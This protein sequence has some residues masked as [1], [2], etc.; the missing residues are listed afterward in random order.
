[1]WGGVTENVA[2]EDHQEQ[3]PVGTTV[4]GT[5]LS[6][7]K[8]LLS[9]M[10]GDRVAH[11]LL[12]T[13]ANID[14]DVRMKASYNSLLLLALLPV[15]KFTGVPK[16]LHGILENRVIHAC[17]DLICEPLKVVARH[18]DW[19]SDHAGN[20]RYCYT[21]IV[22]YIADTP[23]A[24][25]LV[26]VS[27]KT[28]HL[29][30]A[31]GP[32]FGD[33]FQ[34]PPRT[35]S[36]ILSPLSSLSSSMDPWKV[37]AYTKEAKTLYRLNGVDRPFWRDWILTTAGM[38]PN[39]HQIFPIEVL[40]HFHKCFW[41]HDVKWCIRAVGEDE[42]NFRFALLQPRCGYRRFPAGISAL[43]QVTG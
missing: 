1:M 5:I 21:P 35:A 3:V 38:P 2:D 10:S 4:L 13:A 39:P 22:G 25:A 27:G 12:I 9:A 11:L 34:H 23:E 31:F 33:E 24:A 20:V 19:M 42:I 41:D 16:P 43:K 32:H 28:S 8:T 36:D 14:S 29:T 30:L 7:D 18:G 37:A 15:P 40:H 17:L 6:S 26:G